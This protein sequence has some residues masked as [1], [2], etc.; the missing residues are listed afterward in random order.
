[1]ENIDYQKQSI[2]TRAIIK[3]AVLMSEYGA[4]SILIEQTAQRLG[5]ALGVDSVE[6]NDSSCYCFNNFTQTSISYNNKKSSSQT[7]QRQLNVL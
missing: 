2:I 4:E 5:H 7:F 3:A 6:I 1:M